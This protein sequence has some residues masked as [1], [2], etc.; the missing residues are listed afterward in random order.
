[1]EVI[2]PAPVPAVPANEA[3]V[4]T[5]AAAAPTEAPKAAETPAAELYELPD[6]M[7]VDAKGLTEAWRD[8][9]MPEFTRRSQELSA[10]K[11][12]GG[13]QPKAEEQP[14]PAPWTDPAWE[15][16]TYQELVEAASFKAKE[17]TWQK[18]LEE[19]T[20]GEREQAER[21]A[22]VTQEVEQLKGLDPK[23]NVSA[24]MAHASK[25][26]FQSLIPAYQ[27]LKT[28]DEA[29]KRTEERVLKNM[30]QRAGE[31]V[32]VGAADPGAGVT[33]PAHV[34][35]GYEKA[36]WILNNQK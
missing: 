10:L 29:E 14:K 25:F 35:S 2:A 5:P 28:I 3:P 32:G 31:P 13:Q 34:R 36:K 18:V 12:K 11:A 20:R 27:N 16:K 1:M 26:G 7:K 23:V 24:V 9:F 22:Y 6:G 30:K 4:V 19:S 8:R 17:E 33:F 21:D 15:P